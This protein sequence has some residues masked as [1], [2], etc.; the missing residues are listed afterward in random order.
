MQ[1]MISSLRA[2]HQTRTIEPSEFPRQSLRALK[3]HDL[4]NTGHPPGSCICRKIRLSCISSGAPKRRKGAIGI[5]GETSLADLWPKCPPAVLGVLGGDHRRD[6]FDLKSC[7]NCLSLCWADS[8]Q[9]WKWLGVR[10][11][12]L[13]EPNLGGAGG[14][15]SIRLQNCR[16]LLPACAEITCDKLLSRLQKADKT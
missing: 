5:A 13:S 10:S 4:K 1:K 7:L 16:M 2:L 12:A 9:I 15:Y 8:I 6:L 14:A 11:E 3:V